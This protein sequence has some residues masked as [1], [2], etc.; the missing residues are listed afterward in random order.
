MVVIS[1]ATSVRQTTNHNMPLERPY[2]VIRNA[3]IIETAL[4]QENALDLARLDSQR[5]RDEGRYHP[6]TT[7][8]AIVNRATGKT[9]EPIIR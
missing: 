9:I 7:T 8:Y 6:A 1:N 2:A 4:S 3:R 5:L